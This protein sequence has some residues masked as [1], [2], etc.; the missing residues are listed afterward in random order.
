MDFADRPHPLERFTAALA[1]LILGGAVAT[2]LIMLAPLA[3]AALLVAGVG[4][5]A[6]ASVGGFVLLDRI[7]RRGTIATEFEPVAFAEA[8]EL[9]ELL[10][11][12]PIVLSTSRVVQLFK[13][14]PPLPE[15]G[16]LAAR[17]EDF[18]GAGRALPP[19]PA[20]PVA[21]HDATAA[22]HAALADI[23]RSLR[24]G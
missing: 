23:R 16:E 12:E 8:T 14:D 9:D 20:E 17:I 15:P 6:A 1:A 13:P 11:D 24:N 2:S 18:L 7:G 4:G 5:G 19:R 3:G 22:L 10:L 21:R